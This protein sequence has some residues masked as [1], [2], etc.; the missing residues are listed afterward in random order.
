MFGLKRSFIHYFLVPA[1]LLPLVMLAF[2]CSERPTMVGERAESPSGFSG[3]GEVDPDAGD[4]FLLGTATDSTI[5]EG[6]I[7]VW[8]YNLSYDDTAGV[9]SFDVEL[10]NY[11][12]M[13]IPAPIHF[14]IT[15]IMPR[16]IAVMEF[17]GVSGDG[18]PFYDYSSKL[19]PDNVLEPL[20]KTEP[21]TMKFHTGE[22][23]S[24]SIGFRIDLG[25][26]PGMGTIAGVVFR[27]DNRNGVRDRCDRCE[28]GIPGIT[29]TLEVMGDDVP[30]VIFIRQT[31]RDGYFEFSGCKEGLYK[32]RVHPA[33][34]M[35]EI[36]SP[37]PLIVTLVK[38]PDGKVQN[39][40]NANFGLYP[41]GGPLERTLFG[42]ITIGTMTPYGSLL[43]STFVNP[44]SMLPIV[45]TFFLEVLLPP[46]MGPFPIIVDSAAAW[47]NDVQVFDFSA[48]LPDTVFIGELIELPEGLIQ[49]DNTIRLYTNGGEFAALRFRV[50]RVPF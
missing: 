19:G 43:D 31:D 28:P 37:N 41:I 46:I 13:P 42:P 1:L 21:V 50:F 3:K 47:I 45:Y 35:W 33:P 2:S 48:E 11:T 10:V 12:D 25:I 9:V 18:F 39:F 26:A 7:A 27:D 36:T 49:P 17:D 44:P 5:A 16:D 24:F 38:G 8:A 4:S 6:Y 14:V 32:V 40:M 15:W 34:E 23:R 22:P 30:E 20:E 29:V